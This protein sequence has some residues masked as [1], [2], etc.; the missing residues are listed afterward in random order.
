MIP[1]KFKASCILC[2]KVIK[3]ITHNGVRILINLDVIS[4]VTLNIYNKNKCSR[5]YS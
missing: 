2:D 5:L 1:I 4:D 3:D